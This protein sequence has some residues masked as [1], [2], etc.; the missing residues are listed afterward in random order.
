MKVL[1]EE[2][3]AEVVLNG[4][5]EK[6]FSQKELSKLTEID[7]PFIERIERCDFIPSIVQL[8]NLAK[9]LEFDMNYLFVE[10]KPSFSTSLR[11]K[12]YAEEDQEDIGQLFNMMLALRQQIILRKKFLTQDE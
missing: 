2:R 10:R 5:K 11:G 4:R 8:E 6:G 9:T 7:L 3:L 12:K 1:S